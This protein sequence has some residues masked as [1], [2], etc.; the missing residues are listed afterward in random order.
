MFSQFEVS[1]G[2]GY[3]I[4]M[5]MDLLTAFGIIQ[6]N[7]NLL[8][9]TSAGVEHPYYT[10]KHETPYKIQAVATIG[11]LKNPSEL[12][13][14]QINEIVRSLIPT[15]KPTLNMAKIPSPRGTR[16][17]WYVSNS[18]ISCIRTVATKPSWILMRSSF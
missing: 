14:Q 12:Q 16:S 15:P 3:N 9:M 17:I 4:V 8:W 6:D 5:G 2:L 10:S 18:W 11:G 1:K 13:Q 7:R